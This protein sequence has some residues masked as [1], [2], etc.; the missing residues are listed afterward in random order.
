VD[1][2]VEKNQLVELTLGCLTLSTRLRVTDT[3]ISHGKLPN[4]CLV[5]THVPSR[6]T[7]HKL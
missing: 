2:R 5:M 4:T 7:A 6:S 1:C 3:E